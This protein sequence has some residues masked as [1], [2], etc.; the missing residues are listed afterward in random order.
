MDA[1]MTDDATETGIGAASHVLR[2]C[3]GTPVKPLPNIIIV[4]ANRERYLRNAQTTSIA[5]SNVKRQLLHAWHSRD[6][7]HYNPNIDQC[8]ERHYAGYYALELK[9]PFWRKWLKQS[10]I[11][12]DAW[13]KVCAWSKVLD[14]KK[15]RRQ[16]R[17]KRAAAAAEADAANAMDVGFGDTAPIKDTIM[18][19]VSN[20]LAEHEEEEED[21]D[22]DRE[23][24]MDTDDNTEISR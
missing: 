23:E 16:M 14:L 8:F 11:P 3:D 24:D 18:V 22:M 20:V 1:M 5:Q 17:E 12:K 6:P 9:N 10:V 4:G 13:R 7:A 19:D 21:V 2:T 15:K